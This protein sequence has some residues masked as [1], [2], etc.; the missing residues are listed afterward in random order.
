[1]RI[2]KQ[3]KIETVGESQFKIH[4]RIGKKYLFFTKWYKWDCFQE[5]VENSCIEK[6]YESL[7]EALEAIKW[8]FIG[9]TITI[10]D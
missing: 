5:Q 7:S 1:M 6:V 4:Y 10:V 8:Y 3:I 2:I 9:A